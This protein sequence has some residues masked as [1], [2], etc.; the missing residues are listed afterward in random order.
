[1]IPPIAWQDFVQ[2]YTYCTS[3][4]LCS[5]GAMVVAVRRERLAFSY[6]SRQP[7]V[8]SSNWSQNQHNWNSIQVEKNSPHPLPK[9]GGAE[10]TFIGWSAPLFAASFLMLS[11]NDIKHK[12]EKS[13]SNRFYNHILT[14]WWRLSIPSIPVNRESPL[15]IRS[16][17]TIHQISYIHRDNSCKRSQYS[18]K[19]SW[20]R[21][22]R[23]ERKEISYFQASSI[24]VLRFR[25]RNW[26]K[27]IRLYGEAGKM[28]VNNFSS[29]ISQFRRKLQN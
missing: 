9:T 19:I 24:W 13:T 2:M 3:V 29:G 21:E 11:K 16:C 8:S 5:W 14:V 27:S 26:M 17:R 10:L 4:H 12:G 15:S 23:P 28:P 25:E 22:R 20:I 6:R 1:M 18:R 7:S